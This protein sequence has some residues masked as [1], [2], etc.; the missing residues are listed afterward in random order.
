LAT[1][2]GGMNSGTHVGSGTEHRVRTRDYSRPKIVIVLKTIECCIDPLGHIDINRVALFFTLQT[3]DQNVTT[4]FGLYGFGHGLSS[5][6][7]LS[8]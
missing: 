4:Y 2:I 3:N 5:I 1:A 7:S 8:A 6:E